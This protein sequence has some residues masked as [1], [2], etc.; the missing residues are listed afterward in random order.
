VVLSEVGRNLLA[1][2]S[3]VLNEGEAAEA[4]AFA[5]S[6]APRGTVRLA[7]PMS[8]WSRPCGADPA[9]VSDRYPEVMID[10]Y[11]GNE[12]VDLIGG[13]FDAAL[14]IAALSD[15]ILIA[16][17]LC[18]VRR[19]VVAAPGYFDRRDRP[20][21]PSELANHNCLGYAYL[22]SPEVWCFTHIGGDE[23]AVTPRGP[24]R[25]NNADALAPALWSA[26]G[27]AVQPEFT[28]W[29]DI[30]VGRLEQVLPEW[31]LPPLLCIWSHLRGN[32]GQSEWTC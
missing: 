9:R 30:A 31:S 8:F 2:A 27:L 21:H 22:P 13:S 29:K 12:I 11:P 17:R 18:E 14:R 4:Y 7:A 32:F 28:V 16:R 1:H 6:E 20:T 3:Q 19:L 24:L 15:S 23:E 5:Q 10:L 26:L 25:A